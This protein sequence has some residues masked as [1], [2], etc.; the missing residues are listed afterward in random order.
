MKTTG[1]RSM[2]RGG[3]RMALVAA[4]T[5]P[6]VAAAEDTDIFASNA[7][8]AGDL[9][10]IIIILDNSA[11]WS[12]SIGVPNCYYKD[13][14]VLTTRGPS[15][16]GKKVG[17]EKCALYNTIDALPTAK[18]GSALFRVA[19]MLFNESPASV[20]GGYPRI[21]FTPVS[22]TNK[23]SLKAAIAALD[24]QADKGN[25]AAS[26]KALYEAFLYLGGQAPYRGTAGTKWDRAAVSGGRYV[27]PA[28]SSC[29]R[30]YII[31]LANGSPGENT[32]N[33]AR[34]LLA[35]SG[36]DTTQI[37][38][39]SAYVKNSDQANWSDEFARFITATDVSGQAGKQSAVVSTVSVTGASSDGLY[40]NFMRGTA[41][42][43]GGQSYEASNVD[44]LSGAL[45]KLFAEIQSVNS[46]FASSS[47]P[48]SINSRG[49]YQNQVY[50]G[51]FRPDGNAKPRW[52]GN[53]KQYKFNYDPAIDNLYLADADS[54]AAVSST[55]GYVLPTARSY[56]TA[57]SQ[58]WINQPQ[59]TPPSPSDSP[60]G[61][62][63]EKGGAA[64]QLRLA[65]IT[66]A[67]SRRMFT[68]IG[69]IGP[70]VLGSSPAT[71]FSV[72]NGAITAAA[73]G[74]ANAT[75]RQLLID[76]VRGVDNAGDE[77]GPGGTTTVRPSVHGDVL[78]SRPV[79]IN[80]G[81]TIGTVAFYGANDGQL[82]AV[83]A[84]PT[85]SGA[86]AELWSFVPEEHFG[87]LNRLRRNEPPIM[88]PTAPNNVPGAVPRDYFVDG[89]IGLYQKID[90]NGN[91][92]QATIFVAMRRGG[93]LLYAF[94][95]TIPSQP[96]LLWRR[97]Q[98]DLPMLGQ[99]WSEPKVALIKGLAGPA[100]VMGAGYDAAAE[101][102]PSPGATTM[103][104]AVLVLDAATGELL[105]QF[106]P[107]ERSVPAD[108]ALIDS[109]FDGYIDRGYAV[110]IG[111][112]VWRLDMIGTPDRWTSYK[113]A[114]LEGLAGQ[115]RKFFFAPDAVVTRKFTALFL[116]SGDRE[117]PLLSVSSDRFFTLYDTNL[118]AGKPAGFA[119]ITNGQLGLAGSTAAAD[120]SARGCYVD[121]ASGEKVVTGAL[122]MGGSTYF[123]TNRPVPPQPGSCAANLGVAKSY[124]Q[125]IFCGVATS[126]TLV[127]G[128]LPPSPVSGI[129]QIGYTSVDTKQE[130]TKIVPFIIGANNAKRSAIEGAKA[131]IPVA[132]RR[133]RLYWYR[134]GAR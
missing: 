54:N 102:A 57:P 67:D 81:G 15:E 34:A 30:S 129:V 133:M 119:P 5:M 10:N 125:P 96:V 131:P 9:P 113:L 80:Y 110:D 64:Q 60:D 73:L 41:K 61:E 56:W 11:N 6:F 94:D 16:Q 86:G 98:A 36:G 68:C 51:V 21:A 33:E 45:L 88:L 47:L 87:K 109:N 62:I 77:L 44:D 111:G 100:I 49:T 18:D 42:F 114:S 126:T 128:G 134:E 50:M 132:R 83:N 118:G 48:V 31:F 78:H 3:A 65:N 29:T 55:T 1:H 91:T 99:T 75:D 35:S 123:S 90:V 37:T 76:W 85:G 93:R 72:G 69:C 66:S 106:G 12:A 39:P 52:R 38:Y 2:L 127:G 19:L 46:A 82:R 124:Q 59:G 32:D 27:S 115:P 22:A 63:V 130:M 40:P 53:L 70:A 28:A 120:S 7:V 74:V 122:T 8:A 107:F 105:R 84:N 92:L 24:G 104:N 79:V 89:P 95:V 4:L 97:S 43:G 112:D 26:A 25:N 23:I 14:G 58:F 116:G 117:K 121:L 71:Q 101:D 103:G 108:V 17:I 20:S 13:G